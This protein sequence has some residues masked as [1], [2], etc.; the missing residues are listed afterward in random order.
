M[1]KECSFNL[2]KTHEEGTFTVTGEATKVGVSKNI[3]GSVGGA[4]LS[5][6]L[7]RTL[8][9]AGQ[10]ELAEQELI[11]CCKR[12]VNTSH[13]D[14][15]SGRAVGPM[16][17]SRGK[18]H[19]RYFQEVNGFCPQEMA[20]NYHVVSV[21]LT[22]A[23]QLPLV[24]AEPDQHPIDQLQKTLETAWDLKDATNQCKSYC[25]PDRP[26]ASVPRG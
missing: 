15:E 25:G 26:A 19:F 20:I 6:T 10:A 13:E 22:V 18:A 17:V 1:G 11:A 23:A 21:G 2:R 16:L 12:A 7:E 14:L 24:D 9:M 4:W 5:V 8:K 3:Q